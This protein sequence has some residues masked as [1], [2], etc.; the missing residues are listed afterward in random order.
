MS[1]WI[2]CARVESV[3]CVIETHIDA[4]RS[5]IRG[6]AFGHLGRQVEASSDERATYIFF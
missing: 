5:T 1:I 4:H 2:E 3:E 6:D